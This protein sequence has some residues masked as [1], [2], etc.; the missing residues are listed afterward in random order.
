MEKMEAKRSAEKSRSTVARGSRPQK[1]IC[2]L[3]PLDQDRERMKSLQKIADLWTAEGGGAQQVSVLSPVDLGWPSEFIPAFQGRSLEEAA[4]G[5][6]RIPFRRPAG[7]R[8]LLVEATSSRR[9]AVERLID[10][11][12]SQK[13]TLIVAGSHG[14]RG[15]ERAMVGS[16]AETLVSLSP[17]PV[18]VIGPRARVPDRL[19][20]F[21]FATDLSDGSRRA[22]GKAVDFAALVGAEIEIFHHQ[23]Q[24]VEPWAFTGVGMA[25]DPRYFE[26]Y[27]T[28]YRAGLERTGEKWM[29]SVRGAVPVKFRL[30]DRTGRVAERICEGIRQS[31]SDLGVLGLTRGPWSQALFGTVVREVIAES[32][33]PLLMIHVK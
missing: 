16:F 21:L 14:H 23:V 1:V 7:E 8:K 30:D 17:I 15:F 11:A 4:E 2:A 28:D 31:R 18:L 29:K 27:W 19:R 3:D 12:R 9:A 25:L 6:P 26:E 32:E 5:V 22:F 10:H 24:S 13:A 33:R 20:R